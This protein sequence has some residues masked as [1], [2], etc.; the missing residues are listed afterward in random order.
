MR[1]AA[2]SLGVPQWKV[3]VQVLYRCAA[4]G[5]RHR[6]PAG[7]GAHHRRDRA[8]AVHRVQQPVLEHRPERADG[9]R[10][11]GDLPVRDEPLRELATRWPGPAPSCSPCSCCC[12]ASPP[13]PSCCATRSAMT[14]AMTLSQPSSRTVPH[15][16]RPRGKSPA[17]AGRARAWISTTASSQALKN[18]D[19]DIPEK[20]VTALIGPSGCGKS[21]LLRV[22]NRIYALYPKQ[23]AAWRGAA[24]RRE[25]PRPEVSAEPAAQQGRHGVP[26]AGAVPDVD[27]R[28]RRLRHPPPRDAVAHG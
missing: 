23:E 22:F 26:E 28:Q 18:V 7:A 17:Q 10:A 24:G 2:L 21:T 5:H 3:T 8:A 14:E 15:V 6:R 4:A 27:L 16:A 20:R 12:W 1:E 9:Q 25:H 19:L 11:D 13:A